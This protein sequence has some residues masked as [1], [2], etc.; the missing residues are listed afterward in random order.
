MTEFK[1]Y[2]NFIFCS[3]REKNRKYVHTHREEYLGTKSV[4]LQAFTFF[5]NHLLYFKMHT[6]P[7]IMLSFSSSV[8]EVSI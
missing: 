8:G 1:E 6:F 4:V 3:E 2:L 7:F 5:L